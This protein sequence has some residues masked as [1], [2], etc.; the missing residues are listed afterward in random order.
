MSPACP[1]RPSSP[2]PRLFTEIASHGTLVAF[3]SNRKHADLY[4]GGL[5]YD[6]FRPFVDMI[7]E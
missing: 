2:P 3:T 5:S 7:Q 1:L 6:Y 4:K